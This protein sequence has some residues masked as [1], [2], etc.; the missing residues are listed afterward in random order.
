MFGGGK[1]K[2][3]ENLMAT[4]SKAVGTITNVRDTG[5]TINDNPRVNLTFQI[6]PLD[7]GAAFAADKKVTVSRVQIPQPG[8]RF[9]VWFDAEDPTTFA[10]A[11]IT[12]PSGRA[13]IAQLFGDAFGPN[14]EGVGQVAMS[15]PVAAA[16]PA[17]GDPLDQLKKLS[18]LK[19]AGVLTEAEFAEQKAKLLSSM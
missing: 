15:A 6:E 14:G 11:T 4:G 1:K 19:D 2:K 16:A 8:Q 17:G 13:Q 18:E 7:G 5:T 12:D 9:P 10:Y 3:A